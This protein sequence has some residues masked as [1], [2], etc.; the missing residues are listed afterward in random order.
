MMKN[1][2]SGRKKRSVTR[3]RITGP[4]LCR[5]IAQERFPALS[6]GGFWA[7]L[8]H[9]LLD[10]PFDFSVYPAKARS[11]RMRSAPH[12]RLFAAISLIKLIASGVSFGLLERALDL[13]FQTTQKNSRCQREPRLWLDKV[14]RLFPGPC[15]FWPGAPGEA[16]PS[17]CTRVV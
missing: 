13:R 16:R 17:F 2:K 8:L 12:I 7:N 9:I 6:R 4:D 15:P 3:K 14:E 1:A 5:M 10:R 11:P